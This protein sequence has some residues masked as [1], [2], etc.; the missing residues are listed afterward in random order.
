MVNE[1]L[2]SVICNTYNQ[3]DYI[4]DALES[5]IMQKTNFKFEVLVHDDASTDNTANIIREYEQKYPE[6]IKPIYQTVNQ[7]SQKIPIS[8]TYQIPRAKGKYL[9]ACEGDDFWTDPYKLQKQYDAMELHPDVDMCAHTATKVDAITFQNIGEIKP[10]NEDIIF[11]TSDVIRGYG[12]FVATNSLMYKK[13]LT[14]YVPNFRKFLPLDYSLQIHGSLKGG[15][16]YLKDNMSSYRVNAKGSWTSNM[17]KDINRLINHFNKVIQMLIILDEETD[18]KFS[19]AIENVIREREFKIF[20]IQ[21]NYKA[22]LNKKY[23]Q[24]YKGLTFKEKI[25]I[26]LKAYFPFLLKLKRKEYNE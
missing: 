25:K 16:L 2:V 1:I 7:Y 21:Q 6:I 4:R 23:K 12:G 9:A 20:E 11:N 10:S 22:L 15:M 13:E 17:H 3:E 14:S 18:Y 26:R 24:I 8:L 19:S 5:F